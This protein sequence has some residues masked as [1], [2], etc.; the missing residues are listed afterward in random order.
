M[1]KKSW[2]RTLTNPWDKPENA[3]ITPTEL[4]FP[5]LLQSYHFSFKTLEEAAMLAEY[6]SSLYPAHRQKIIE[7]GL[8]ELFLNAIE[9]GNLGINASFKSHLKAINSW[10][11]E[12]IHRLN[13]EFNQHKDVSVNLEI[14]PDYLSLKITDQGDGFDWRA[15]IESHQHSPTALHGR[16]LL[17]CKE[18]CFD[19][20]TFSEKGN[21]VICT[22]YI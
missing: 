17:M 11:K 20:M 9:H 14:T 4:K 10:E 6:L 5:H 15:F 2:I 22:V 1:S 7:L 3:L 19:E 21:E 18:L 13:H 16:G 8:N 12:I